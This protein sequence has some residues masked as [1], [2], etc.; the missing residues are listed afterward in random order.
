MSSLSLGSTFGEQ[1]YTLNIDYQ[2]IKE[3]KN[4]KQQFAT[5]LIDIFPVQG[6]FGMFL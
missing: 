1:R 6:I 3:T 2:R 5:K 4:K